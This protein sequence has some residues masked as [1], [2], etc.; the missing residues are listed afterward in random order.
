MH[1]LVQLIGNRHLKKIIILIET[2]F[3]FSTIECYS[4][5]AIAI[6]VI[7]S[8]RNW[9]FE[10]ALLRALLVTAHNPEPIRAHRGGAGYQEKSVVIAKKSLPACVSGP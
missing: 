8:A 10:D 2:F 4:D 9:K 3:V 1:E 7:K 6:I 5:D